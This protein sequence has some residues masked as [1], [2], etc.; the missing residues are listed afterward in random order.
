MN[1]LPKAAIGVGIGLMILS[2]DKLFDSSY[3]QLMF[4]AGIIV[5]GSAKLYDLILKL[6]NR[7]DDLDNGLG[8]L[9]KWSVDEIEKKK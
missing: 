4:L 2:V 5:I 3:S 9:Q 8:A 7:M 6:S 1:F